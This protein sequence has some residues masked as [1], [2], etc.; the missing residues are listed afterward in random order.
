MNEASSPEAAA[1]GLTA[2]LSEHSAVRIERQSLHDLVANRLRDLIIEGVLTPGMRLNESRL[3]EELGVSR[4][5]LR[6]AVKTLAS[7]GLIEPRP[8]RGTVVRSFNAK[9]ARDMLEVLTELEAMAG[10]LACEQAS[11]AQIAE[12]S[13]VHDRMVGFYRSKERLSYY[14]LNQAIHSMIVAATGNETLIEMHGML[15]SRMKRLRFIGNS[16]T[17][18]WKAALAEHDEMIAALK[19]RDGAALAEVLQRHLRNTWVRVA[20]SF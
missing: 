19:R 17:E 5:P 16:G 10:R 14:K 1:A 9:D 12:I 13:A 8:G 15:Q 6:E 3:C 4:T 18:K 11:D 2:P 7:E 20:D